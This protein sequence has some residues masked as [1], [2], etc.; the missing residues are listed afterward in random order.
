MKWSVT[1]NKINNFSAFKKIAENI[2]DI[3]SIQLN[4]MYNTG[5]VIC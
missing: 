5:Y 1:F 4:N 2:L 3:V